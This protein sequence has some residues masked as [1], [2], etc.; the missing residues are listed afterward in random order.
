LAFLVPAPAR[1]DEPAPVTPAP[2]AVPAEP[3]GTWGW[4]VVASSVALGIGTTIY[5]LTFRCSDTDESCA[6]NAGLAIWGGAGIAAVGT[7]FGVMVVQLGQARARVAP[8]AFAGS[9]SRSLPGFV[10]MGE[11]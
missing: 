9:S 7:G 1:A 6:R 4:Y 10:V 11:F 8:K 5:G 3:T 2:P